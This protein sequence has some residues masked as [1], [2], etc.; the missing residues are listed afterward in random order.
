MDTKRIENLQK[1]MALVMSET[2]KD[3]EDMEGK[4]FTGKVVAEYH[5]Y[6]SA[7]IVAIAETVNE[8]LE[9]LKGVK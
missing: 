8:I 5:G 4:P 1:K 7:G 3:V 9:E 6:M 2:K